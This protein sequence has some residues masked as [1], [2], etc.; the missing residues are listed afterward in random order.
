[1]VDT[2]GYIDKIKNGAIKGWLDNKILPSLTMAQGI[3]ESGWGTS[4][5]A[6]PPFHNNFGIKYNKEEDAGKYKYDLFETQE[7][8]KNA[9]EYVWIKAPFRVYDSLDASVLDHTKFFTSTPARV[10]RYAKVVGERDYVRACRA[11]R[12]AG[13]ATDPLYDTKLINIINQYNLVQYDKEA[14]AKEG[15]RELVFWVRNI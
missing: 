15:H 7:W 2:K 10:T 12:L 11:V 1:M 3:L 5:L 4:R 13:Y 9:N 8:D 6:Q 14:F